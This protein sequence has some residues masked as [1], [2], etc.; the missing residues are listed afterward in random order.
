M[1]ISEFTR[2]VSIAA[3]QAQIMEAEFAANVDVAPH[4]SPSTQQYLSNLNAALDELFEIKRC[5]VEP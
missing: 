5:G 4:I 3:I 2:A 1:E